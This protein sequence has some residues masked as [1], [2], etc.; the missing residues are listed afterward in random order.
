VIQRHLD[1][2]PNLVLV[3][4]RIRIRTR[5]RQ[6][7]VERG[8]YRWIVFDE[9]RIALRALSRLALLRYL[10]TTEGAK[11]SEQRRFTTIRVELGD[12]LAQDDLCRF[13]SEVFVMVQA[14]E[15]EP[16]QSL[17]VA[18]EE[19]IERRSIAIQHAFRQLLVCPYR[20]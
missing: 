12:R 2:A 15:S 4:R 19:R 5:V 17:V 6:Q 11:P 13:V 8:S 20:H 3:N 18:V 14:D 10:V 1:Q 9:R 16:V 7:R